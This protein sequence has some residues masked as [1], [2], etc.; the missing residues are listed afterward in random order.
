M[1]AD[2]MTERDFA[3]DLEQLLTRGLIEVDGIPGDDASPRLRPTAAGRA[4]IAKGDFSEFAEGRE[5]IQTE[6][7]P[8]I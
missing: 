6:G 2:V 4:E 8:R 7:G 3:T 1:K 5:E